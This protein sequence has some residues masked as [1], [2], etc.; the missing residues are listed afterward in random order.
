L[1]SPITVLSSHNLSQLLTYKGLQTLSLSRVLFLQVAL[2]EDST[3]TFQ[4]CLLLNI[5][6]FFI[7][8][9]LTTP[10]LTPKLKL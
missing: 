5:P 10:Y 1:G 9:I 3:F 8:L 2:I 7:S 4:S 6:I